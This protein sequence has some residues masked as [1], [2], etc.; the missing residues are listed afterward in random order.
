MEDTSKR[1]EE[2]VSEGKE[3]GVTQLVAFPEALLVRDGLS[4]ELLPTLLPANIDGYPKFLLLGTVIGDRFS[5]LSGAVEFT[6]HKFNR[7]SLKDMWCL[8][9]CVIEGGCGTLYYVVVFVDPKLGYMGKHR[10]LAPTPLERV[11]RG[12]GYV[13]ILPVV[14]KSPGCTEDQMTSKSSISRVSR[15]AVNLDFQGGFHATA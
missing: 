15:V 3:R 12:Q 7:A 9:R 2:L 4:P 5:P 8:P 13:S 14:R 1:L 10:K 11:V 6:S